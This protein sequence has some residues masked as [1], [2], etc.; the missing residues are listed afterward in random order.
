MA[1]RCPPPVWQRSKWLRFQRTP[2]IR[3]AGK[4]LAGCAEAQGTGSHSNA[5]AAALR[6]IERMH[7]GSQVPSPEAVRVNSAPGRCLVPGAVQA[8]Q[9]ATIAQETTLHSLCKTS[10]GCLSSD[11]SRLEDDSVE[12]A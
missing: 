8:V 9:R 3:T 10:F 4:S 5:S 7:P 12:G 6:T 11:L 1:S 2:A